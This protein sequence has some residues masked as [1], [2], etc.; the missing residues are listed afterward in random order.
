MTAPADVYLPG[1]CGLEW[2][3]DGRKFVAYADEDFVD[4]W[5]GWTRTLK[6]IGYSMKKTE[7]RWIGH[8]DPRKSDKQTILETLLLIR[9]RR[10]EKLGVR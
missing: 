9:T 3:P 4:L 10:L 5:F 2:K 8:F 1:L 6:G 7:G